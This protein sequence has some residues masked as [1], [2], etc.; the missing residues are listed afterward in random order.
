MRLDGDGKMIIRAKDAVKLIGVSIVA[1][2]AVFVCTLF[3]NFLLDLTKIEPLI[4]NDAVRNF[5]E[6][7]S[8]TS[9]ITCSISGGCLLLTSVVMLF[10][11]IKH[12]IDTHKKELGILKALGYSNLQIAK[13]FWV[14][15]LCIFTGTALGFASS[16]LLMPLFYETMNEEHI[17][18]DIA[19]HVHPSLLLALVLLPTFVFALLSILYSYVQLKRPALE[20]LR[21]KSLSA[22]KSKK[23]KAP[24][25]TETAFLQEL[26]RSTVKSRPA[27]IFFIAFSAFCYS[28]M[29]QMSASMNDLASPLFAGMI[30][31]I[32]IILAFT[33][34]LLSVT[35]VVGANAPSISIMTVFGYSFKECSGAILNGYRPVAYLGFAVG[36]VYQY[37]LL[38]LMVK[39]FSSA[40]E[41][42][43][44]DAI[45]QFEFNFPVFFLVLFSFIVVYEAILYVYSLRIKHISI[46]EIMSA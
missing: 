39:L 37:A 31:F 26:K 35:T 24:K 8:L 33:T 20:L 1:F 7:Q 3:M 38:K 15:G 11:Y 17:L 16:F 30:F 40:S 46:K 42:I 27:L 45:P 25:Q 18:P 22:G 14:F 6:A 41:A 4:T 36:T 19:L 43:P 5:Y 9:K 32:G 13:H 21:G 29:L 23:A 44:K 34:L 10:F 12:Y 28:A 2:C